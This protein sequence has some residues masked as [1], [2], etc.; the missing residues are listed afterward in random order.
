MRH[1]SALIGWTYACK[2]FSNSSLVTWPLI[3]PS[4]N[5][6]KLSLQ[7]TQTCLPVS[8]V[9]LLEFSTGLKITTRPDPARGFLSPNPT[10]P[11]T[12]AWI[13][14]PNRAQTWPPRAPALFSSYTCY[15]NFT[16]RSRVCVCPFPW[17]RQPDLLFT[18]R[19]QRWFTEQTIYNLQP[20]RNVF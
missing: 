16:Q 7:E 17:S 20:A 19:E 6:H 14:C 10:Q 4:I 12:L 5:V 1:L 15:R 2:W 11:N 3:Y 9:C 13:V 8:P 18:T